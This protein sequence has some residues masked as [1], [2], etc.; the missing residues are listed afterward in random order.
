MQFHYDND[1]V[2]DGCLLSVECEEWRSSFFVATRRAKGL[3]KISWISFFIMWARISQ[4]INNH[5]KV[6]KWWVKMVAVCAF[7][8]VPVSLFLHLNSPIRGE[9]MR[10]RGVIIIN[11]SSRWVA[12]KVHWSKRLLTL[13]NIINRGGECVCVCVC[14]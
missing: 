14:I 5:V 6:N 1:N 8:V 11:F 3:L 2:V 7:R 12:W 9:T 10:R 4:K 13:I